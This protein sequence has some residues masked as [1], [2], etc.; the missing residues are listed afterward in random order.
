[1]AEGKENTGE[2][3]Q[4]SLTEKIKGCIERGG[5][6]RSRQFLDV[7]DTVCPFSVYYE[8][9]GGIARKPDDVQCQ[10]ASSHELHI[11]GDKKTTWH[12]RA[13]YIGLKP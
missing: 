12:Y 10:H 1:M 8:I 13:C 4:K 2:E 7:T 9:E 5:P 6:D 11:K 3:N